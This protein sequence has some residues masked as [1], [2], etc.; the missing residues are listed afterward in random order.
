[1]KL[2]FII[3]LCFCC[4]TLKAQDSKTVVLPARHATIIAENYRQKWMT[5]LNVIQTAINRAKKGDYV[6]LGKLDKVTIYTIADH[7]IL[8]DSINLTGQGMVL[9]KRSKP[10]SYKLTSAAAGPQITLNTV[11][12]LSVG[13]FLVAIGGT[14]YSKASIYRY[15]VSITGNMINLSAPFGNSNDNTITSWSSGTAIVK[16]YNM[17][18]FPAK[19]QINE[20]VTISI[21][22]ISFDGNKEETF[23]NSAYYI[24]SMILLRSKGKSYIKRCHF[25]NM[26]NENIV[27][28]NLNISNSTFDNLNGSAV[29]FSTSK[30][31]HAEKTLG[32]TIRNCIIKNTNIVHTS[33]SGHSEG[34]FTTSN[35]GGYF[36]AYGNRIENSNGAALIGS[37]YPS[38]SRLDYG[39][40][41]I[42]V[43]NNYLDEVERFFYMID[44]KTPGDIK[45]VNVFN[46]IVRNVPGASVTRKGITIG[47]NEVIE[48][49]KE[50]PSYTIKTSRIVTIDT[51]NRT[52]YY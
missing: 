44:V 29:H 43:R 27:G 40:N 17:I 35:S 20:D 46:N 36:T 8:R 28:H 51:T 24:N 49:S 13:D 38:L 25:Y 5:D 16:S 30:T 41:E 10:A 19:N 26:P 33:L 39:T 7:I 6:V 31:L 9:I 12:G 14:T 34:V 32:S 37:L 18:D 47:L 23:Q 4:S 50:Q 1:M 3:S 48:A 42:T 52:I 15:I 2:L 45:D 22:N 11:E 21:D